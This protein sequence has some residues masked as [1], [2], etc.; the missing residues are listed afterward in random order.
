[1]SQAGPT[2]AEFLNAGRRGRDRPCPQA[3]MARS[4]APA[5]SPAPSSPPGRSTRTGELAAVVRKALGYR[6][7]QKSDPGDPHLPGDPHPFERRARRARAGLARRRARASARRPA[8]GRHLPQPRGPDRQA[9]PQGA[10]RRTPAGSR[11]RPQIA[12]GPAPTFEQSPS[13]STRRSASWPATRARARRGCVP[14]SA[15]MRPRG[16]RRRQHERAR[17][18]VGVHGRR[19][20]PAPRSAATWSRCTSPRSAPSW[21]MS[22]PKIVLA[23]RDIRVLQTEIGTRGRLAQLERWNARFFAL[24]APSA[25]QFVE[26]GFQLAPAGRPEQP[27]RIR[28]AGGARRGARASRSARRGA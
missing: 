2:A 18:Q 8:R 11:H 27:G 1:M 10:Q 4:R 14:L 28:G 25:D 17:L 20:S 23:Q 3:T 6:Q 19:A 7:G 5:R 21:R 22:R 9:L 13:Q 15:P 16:T 26:G 12:G 24:S